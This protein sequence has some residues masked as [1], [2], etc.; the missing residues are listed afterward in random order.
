MNSKWVTDWQ[1]E[2]VSLSFL[3]RKAYRFPAL[4]KYNEPLGL[5]HLLVSP[6]LLFWKIVQVKPKHPLRTDVLESMDC[7]QK[8]V[9][10]R[11]AEV[12][13]HDAATLRKF[14]VPRLPCIH[15]MRE[16]VT[17]CCIQKIVEKTVSFRY[18]NAANSVSHTDPTVGNSS[19]RIICKC[20]MY[21]FLCWETPDSG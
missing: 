15:I 1:W 19:N 20:Q 2:N 13:L 8:L 18:Y 3:T 10:N 5:S 6:L 17:K 4:S 9:V 16:K 21:A 12:L 7:L 11:L 14:G